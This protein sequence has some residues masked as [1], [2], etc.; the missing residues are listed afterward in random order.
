MIGPAWTGSTISPN[1]VVAVSLNLEKIRPRFSRL[2][3]LR[4]MWLITDAYTRS[5][6]LLGSIRMRLT[7]KSPIPR[8]RM[9]AL[10]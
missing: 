5:V 2:V 6:E 9:R 7:S 10:R 1:E 4:P 3:R 8:D